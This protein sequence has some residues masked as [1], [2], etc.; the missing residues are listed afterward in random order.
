M[1]VDHDTPKCVDLPG[2]CWKQPD[3][4]LRVADWLK[5]PVITMVGFLRV[6]GGD[7]DVSPVVSWS[8]SRTLTDRLP[9]FNPRDRTF[10]SYA[11][12]GLTRDWEQYVAVGDRLRLDTTIGCGELVTSAGAPDPLVARAFAMLLASDRQLL[13]FAALGL[14]DEDAARICGHRVEEVPAARLRLAENLRHLHPDA[15][16]LVDSRDLRDL[17][18]L[19]GGRL[20]SVL[21]LRSTGLDCQA[22]AER[23]G[24]DAA[25][26][27]LLIRNG[28]ETVT[29]ELRNRREA[30]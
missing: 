24:L 9:S 15:E 27:S 12:N 10:L 26:V 28:R 16:P 21:A 30:R 11:W 2:H 25:H 4:V 8:L 22:I 1:K 23:L 18:E 7:E 20:C 13:R 5:R 29:R 14:S 19:R 6:L 3:D 17:Q